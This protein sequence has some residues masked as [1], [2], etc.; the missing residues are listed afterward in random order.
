MASTKRATKHR[1]RR[2]RARKVA[3]M[4]AATIS[5]SALTVGMAPP[6]PDPQRSVD[7][8]VALAAAPNYTQIIENSSNSLDN[9]LYVQANATNAL[10]TVLNPLAAL[11][12]GLLPTVGAD[13]D[14]VQVDS[15]ASL[16]SALGIV[17][18]ALSAVPNLSAIPGLP[19]DATGILNDAL[20]LPSDLGL[21]SLVPVLGEAAVVLGVVDGLLAVLSTNPLIS[22]PTLDEVLDAL[23][24]TVEATSFDSFL[25]WPLLGINGSTNVT[26]V[27]AQL[28]SLTGGQLVTGILD[29]VTLLNGNPL[30]PALR[31]TLEAL[32][33]PLDP[34]ATPSV[35]AWL[36]ITTG[37]YT[38]PLGGSLGWLATMPTVAVGPIDLLGLDIGET[39][40]AVPLAAGGVSLP[41]GLA[42][43][44][45]VF[46]PGVVFPTATGVS[47]LG[48]TN[49]Q[50]LIIPLLGTSITNINTLNSTYV[51]TN[52]VNYNSG[53]SV[54]LVTTPLGVLPLVYSMGK[55]NFGT[56]GFG[57]TGP[58][59]FGVGLIPPIQ[60]GTAPDQQSPDGLIP[61]DVLNLGL[62]LPTQVTSVTELLGLPDPQDAV[63]AFV[64]PVFNAAFAPLGAMITAYLNDNIGSWANG[65]SD[66]AL[67]LTTFLRQLSEQ[68]PNAEQLPEENATLVAAKEVNEPQATVTAAPQQPTTGEAPATE[69]NVEEQQAE[70]K[71]DQ[72]PAGDVIVDD[73]GK[74]D[75]DAAENDAHTTVNKNFTDARDRL[76]RIA[77]DGQKRINDTVSGVSKGI[78]DTAKKIGDGIQKAGDDVKKALGAD[79]KADADKKAE[80]DKKAGADK[81]ATSTSDND[82]DK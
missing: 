74:T 53:Q 32:L 77:A 49:L 67:Q 46:T 45:T 24:L 81:S 59:L 4:S 37:A 19:A 29:Q 52:G 71:G 48:G 66:L 78:N 20:G 43:F 3:V 41:L 57:F 51:G 14:H 76:N 26:N 17:A 9:L 47:T 23:G 82:A 25:S 60:V 15:L 73:T 30:P 44:G 75:L 34:L 63:D 13:V 2:Q 62:D 27:F 21:A 80:A 10:A 72:Q 6:P 40:V 11:S 61:A 50:S 7:M 70:E 22:V 35:T 42:S 8:Q 28:D 79:K 5:A 64:N 18:N 36:P 16:L 65:S 1:K 68:L 54:L 55:V 12:F 31:D 33:T 69:L 56:T 58:S 38:L 39:V